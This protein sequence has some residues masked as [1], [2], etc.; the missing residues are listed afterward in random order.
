MNTNSY[1]IPQMHPFKR[2][3]QHTGVNL[4]GLKVVPSY[5]KPRMDALSAEVGDLF[6]AR[7]AFPWFAVGLQ[8]SLTLGLDFLLAGYIY[9]ICRIWN[10][11]R[12]PE[13]HVYRHTIYIVFW[14]ISVAWNERT[15]R[16]R[17]CLCLEFNPRWVQDNLSVPLWAYMRFHMSG[18]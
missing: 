5:I 14:T 1:L 18:H 13:C 12:A 3:P 2:I 15:G 8:S 17:C 10:Q 7:N 16:W 4:L 9:K 11:L 6:K